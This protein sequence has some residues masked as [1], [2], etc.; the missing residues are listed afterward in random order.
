M[1][2]VCHTY[3]EN[4]RCS[5]EFSDIEG[6][7]FTEVATTSDICACGNIFVEIS[8]VEQPLD[9]LSYMD[10]NGWVSNY[11]DINKSITS[12]GKVIIKYINRYIYRVVNSLEVKIFIEKINFRDK[13]Q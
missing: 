11:L 3:V 13:F 2:D 1:V 9:E 7:Y 10:E 4:C 6:L 5:D 12:I 8:R